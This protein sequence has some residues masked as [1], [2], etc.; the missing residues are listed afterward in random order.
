MPIYLKY[1]DIKGSATEPA[2]RGYI[3]LTSFQWG[4]GRGVTSSTGGSAERE[5][6]VPFV[7]EIVV[8][9]KSDSASH[10]LMTESL[11]GE[12]VTAVIDFVRS[13]GGS[14]YLRLEMSGTMISGWSISS[15]GDRPTESLTLNFTKMEFKNIPGTPPP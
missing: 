12:P 3:E 6:S 7:R 4:V 1:G 9:K 11:T 14:V 8:T 15:G 13:D 5:S 2:H 10:R